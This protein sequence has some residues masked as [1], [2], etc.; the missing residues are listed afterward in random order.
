MQGHRG[1]QED[2]DG[3]ESQKSFEV[4]PLYKKLGGEARGQRPSF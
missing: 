4:L 1:D 2:D 3:G